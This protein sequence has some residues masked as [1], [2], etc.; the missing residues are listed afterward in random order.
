MYLRATKL[1]RFLPSLPRIRVLIDQTGNFGNQAA[2]YNLMQK[3]RELGFTGDFELIYFENTKAKVL[4]LFDLIDLS[5]PRQYC[6]FNKIYFVEFNHYLKNATADTSQMLPLGISGAID[7]QPQDWVADGTTTN[8]YAE[9]FQVKVFIRFSAF[10]NIDDLCDTEIYRSGQSKPQVQK[11][12]CSKLLV[13]PGASFHE[14]YQYLFSSL[15]GQMLASQYPILKTV[16]SNIQA[17]TINF[18]SIYGWTLRECPSNLFNIILGARFAQMH[19]GDAFGKPLV[20]GAFFNLNQ[21]NGFYRTQKMNVTNLALTQ[22]LLEDSWGFYDSYPGAE[23]ARAAARELDLK[24]ALRLAD[25][26]DGDAEEQVKE[27]GPNQVLLLNLP[28]LPKTLFDGL[29]THDAPNMLPSVREGASSFTSL[30]TSTAMPHIHCRKDQDWEVDLRL[31]DPLLAKQLTVFNDIVCP[32]S[33]LSD[34]NF[35]PWQDYPLHRV[36]GNYLLTAKDEHSKL[37]EYFAGLQR[38]ALQPQNDRILQDMTA[39]VNLLLAKNPVAPQPVPPSL[40]S[41]NGTLFSTARGLFRSTTTAIQSNLG[42]LVSNGYETLKNGFSQKEDNASATSSSL[43]ASGSSAAI[44]LALQK[45]ETPAKSWVDRFVL[46]PMICYANEVAQN[47]PTYFPPDCP[48]FWQTQGQGLQD[49]TLGL[50]ESSAGVS[51]LSPP[52]SLSSYLLK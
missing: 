31:A 26:L 33:Y 5:G 46:D 24:N 48:H 17:G 16:F 41:S 19:G 15:Q 25:Y 39:G 27:L 51:M 9:F 37:S 4:Q 11:D 45:N 7:T 50:I 20:I 28:P 21:P 38:E 22:F 8:N 18:Q 12:S 43:P 36:I 47:C 49:L 35:S 42:K 6:P 34:L 23:E 40:L 2:T 3:L 32:A 30:I 29:F 13:T 1:A 10:Y 14:A 52:V 44:T